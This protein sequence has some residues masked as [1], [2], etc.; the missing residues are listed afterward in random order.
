[1]YVT[2]NIYMDDFFHIQGMADS[3][4]WYLIPFTDCFVVVFGGRHYLILY[5][6]KYL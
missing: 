3:S 2:E 4:Y 1:M 6:D 5:H